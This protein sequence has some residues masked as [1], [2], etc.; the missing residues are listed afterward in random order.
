MKKQYSLRAVALAGVCLAP[1]AAA[2]QNF[3]LGGAGDASATPAKE[4]SN[5]IDVGVR[6]QS[7]TSPVFG[8]YTG[9]D[10][11]G[12]GSLGG[13]HLKGGDAPDSGN[14]FFYE[15]T[16]TNLDFQPNNVG[17]NNALAPE[18]ELNVAVGQQGTWKANAYYNAITYTGQTFYSPYNAAGNL[19]PGLTPFGGKAAGSTLPASGA[20]GNINYYVNNNLPEFQETAGT[21]R[22]IVG[23]DGKYILGEWTVTS[24]LR[25]EHKEG[26]VMQ[27]VYAATSGTAFPEPVNYDTDRYNVTGAYNTRK[28]QTQIG[29]VY[30]RFT[31]NNTFFTAPYFTAGTSPV[32]ATNNAQFTTQYSLPPSNSAH[33]INGAFGYNLTPETRATANFQYGLE[34]SDSTLGAGTATP[35]SQIGSSYSYVG[36]NEN[37]TGELARVYNANVGLT[38][39]PIPALDFKVAYG[40][41]GRD[42]NAAAAPIY[43]DAH[44]DGA[45]T[46]TAPVLSIQQNWTKQKATAEA[47]YKVLPSTKVSLGYRFD[48][49]DRSSGTIANTSFTGLSWVGR[50]IENTEWVKV[51]DHSIDKVNSSITYEHAQRGGKFDLQPVTTSPT[52]SSGVFYQAP[53][54]AD[55]VKLR[56][57]YAPTDEWSIGANAK[58]ETNHYTYTSTMTG[59]DRDYNASAGPDVSYTPTKALS[60]HA[61]YTYEEI[62]YNN[63]GNGATSALDSGYGWSAATTDSVHTAGFSADWKI[64]DRL[65]IGTEYTFS[66][67][68]V[69]YNLFGG[70]LVSSAAAPLSYYNVQNLPTVNSSMHSL[71]LRGEYAL[72]DNIS[73][74]AG[75]G[76]DLFKDNDWSYGWNPVMTANSAGTTPVTVNSLTSAE[77][78][79]SYRVHSVYTAVRV[80]F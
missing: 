68:D 15:A 8:R 74:L 18:S 36:K 16:G 76:F 55:R 19:A 31:D 10:S 53:R 13:F 77:S 7:N 30:S 67:G 6:Y 75:Y 52:Y 73:L 62:Y 14:T 25:H 57:D 37:T 11:K 79:P 44:G 59:T 43:G 22:D 72:A 26:T 42:N 38:S 39:R 51:A 32:V 64:T 33:Y 71:K 5:E 40:L 61:F 49:T 17:P 56:A 1:L 20:P 46:T 29:Y 2:A 35:G 9:N 21:R 78:N 50:S 60:F 34:M 45:L 47:G 54:V 28:L 24:G 58:Y 48:D 66:Y 69:A 12:F 70:G 27:T 65:K 3:D 23:G 80:K 41:D 4:Y 63:G